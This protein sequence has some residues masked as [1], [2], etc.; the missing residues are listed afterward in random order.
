MDVPTQNGSLTR[1]ITSIG[2]LVGL[3][4]LLFLAQASYHQ[5][6]DVAK[7][8]N[9]TGLAFGS[10]PTQ[11][12]KEIALGVSCTTVPTLLQVALRGP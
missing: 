12:R 4:F 5:A 7:A 2:T 11:E 1:D 8:D 6:V 10:S 3:L 9:Q